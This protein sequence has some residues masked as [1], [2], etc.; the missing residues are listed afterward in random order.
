MKT[1]ILS[2]VCA[3]F[4]FADGQLCYQPDSTQ[5][6]QQICVAVSADVQ[7]DIA[8]YV[9]APAN[10]ITTLG[11]D[12]TSMTAPKYAGIGDAIFQNIQIM[13][14]GAL[15]NFPP[16]SVQSVID[17]Q[18][19]QV[20]AVQAAISAAAPKVAPQADPAQVA[21]PPGRLPVAQPLGAK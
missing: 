6:D 19:A 4:A 13:F 14:I 17:A 15:A 16:P 10:Q 3:L 2:L 8:S 5:P 18:T 20:V 12:G 21:T 11:P 9:A 1:I 7:T